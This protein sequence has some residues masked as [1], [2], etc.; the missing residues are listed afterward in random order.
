MKKSF[1]IILFLL[2]L[3]TSCS[4]KDKTSGSLSN[5][6]SE[7]PSGI[8]DNDD[9]PF[10]VSKRPQEF[11]LNGKCYVYKAN[12]E[13]DE[14]NISYFFGYFINKDD[15]DKW[16]A[17]DKSDAIIY[18]TDNNNSIY[19]YDQTGKLENRFELF[20]TTMNNEM[21]LKDNGSYYLY[22]LIDNMEK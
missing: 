6:I 20:L 19:N 14:S 22:V 10:L 16:K 11:C 17:Y 13:L 18:V 15:L 7:D 2:S 5:D 21:A 1:F 4:S 3:L 12:T 8:I 9:N